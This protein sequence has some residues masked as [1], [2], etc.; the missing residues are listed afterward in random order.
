MIKKKNQYQRLS[1]FQKFLYRE[2]R[3]YAFSKYTAVVYVDDNAIGVA[4]KAMVIFNNNTIEATCRDNDGAKTMV[5]G[6]PE[7][8]ISSKQFISND[9]FYAVEAFMRGQQ[10][11]V[12]YTLEHP[13]EENEP[14]FESDCYVVDINPLP[15]RKHL[16]RAYVKLIG[17]TVTL[18]TEQ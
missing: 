5:L 17:H 8:E 14:I 16:Q 15:L 18:H 3:K 10:T 6:G 12:R 9:M 4:N 11:T 2:I 1:A 7:V 13:T